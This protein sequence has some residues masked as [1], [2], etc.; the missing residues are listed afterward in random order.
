MI[1]NRERDEQKQ[2]DNNENKIKI[3]N[4]KNDNNQ[5]INTDKWKKKNLILTN[6]QPCLLN[7]KNERTNKSNKNSP[8][9]Q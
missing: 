6:K 2:T 1:I 3:T 9:K 4:Q 7:N 5:P 8:R